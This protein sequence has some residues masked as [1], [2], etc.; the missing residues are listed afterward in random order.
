[1]HLP[2]G[3]D[4]AIREHGPNLSGIIREE[5]QACILRHDFFGVQ[6]GVTNPVYQACPELR[7]VENDGEISDLLRLNEQQRLE[8]FV[9]CSKPA[10]KNDESI[11][12]FDEHRLAHEEVAEVKR[13]VKVR[14]WTLLERQLDIA[15]YGEVASLLRTLI[16]RL[17]DA[18]P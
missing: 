1:M 9:H 6:H 11:R 8:E 2:E 17:H 4:M 12:V 15:A 16:R 10:W 18:R 7:I 5:Q 3:Y 13:D 14:V